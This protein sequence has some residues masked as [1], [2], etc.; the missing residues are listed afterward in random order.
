MNHPFN[1]CGQQYG[2]CPRTNSC[3]TGLCGENRSGCSCQRQSWN[4]R[5]SSCQRQPWTRSGCGLGRQAWNTRSGCGY[6]SVAR[7]TDC[8]CGG[9]QTTV[10]RSTDC[11]CG[12]TQ[13][14]VTRSTDCGGGTQ[15]TVT[16]STDCGCGNTTT[17]VARSTDCGCADCNHGAENDGILNGRSLAMVYAP[18]QKYEELYDPR[19][20]LCNG[21][22]F[23]NLNKPFYGD[24]GC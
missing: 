7:S 19:V 13:T 6:E 3:G 11:G 9:T 17:T 1:R 20:G 16:R 21:T 22:I 24:R 15:T 5:A 14:T 8:G 23:C 2:N 4:N 10:T 12:G 18:Y